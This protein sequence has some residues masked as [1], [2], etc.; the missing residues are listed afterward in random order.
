MRWIACLVG[1]VALLA[2]ACGGGSG[3]EADCGIEVDVVLWGGIQWRELG[4]AIAGDL[5]P[6]ADYYISVPP[7][8]SDKT[9]LRSRSEFNRLRALDPH[10]HPVA[11]IRFTSET[12]WRAW[13]V[14]PHPEWA[15]GRTFY[16][17]GVEAR[18][19]ME[20]RGL[21]V[22][23][24]ET[25]A[26]NEL[27]TDVLENVPGRRQEI[28][29]FLRGLHEGDDMED[30]RG[31]VF[32]IGAPADLTDATSYKE[33]LKGWLT[34]GP[35]WS[36]V[37]ESVD[38]FANEVYVGP[39]TWGES[40]TTLPERTESLND[41][42]FHMSS[43]AEA[44]PDSAEPAREFLARTYVPLANAA[45]PHELIGRTNL[46]AA[47]TMAQLVSAQVY[48]MRKYT[49]THPDSPDGG[50]GFAWA[51]NPAE[52][53]YSEKGRD[54]VLGRLARA[55][56]AAYREG[57]VSETSVCGSSGEQCTGDVEGASLNDAWKI[58]A[59]WD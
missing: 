55:I 25:W 4:K 59:S 47:D 28:R 3:S 14:G 23:E 54:F 24:G 36:D 40:G 48:A 20:E 37:D 30:S 43:L 21:N 10:I 42:L 16:D 53:R 2:T 58:F 51:P 32:N 57:A 49:T 12:G 7:Q 50:I 45:W 26:L 27:D 5:T 11:E 1:V 38:F 17:A 34:D 29:E 19:R 46:I 15:P 41:F 52:P 22:A 44:G 31:I 13:V 6:C 9:Q 56:H 35:F 8:D 33:N 39:L 18:R